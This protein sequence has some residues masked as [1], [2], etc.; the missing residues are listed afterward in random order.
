MYDFLLETLYA[1]YRNGLS[2]SALGAVVYVLL[3]QRKVR[4]ILKSYIPWLLEDDSE[5]KSY[6]ENQIVIMENQKRMMEGMG[7]E[8]HVPTSIKD[9]QD[10]VKKKEKLWP[11]HVTMLL[12]VRYVKKFMKFGGMKMRN[13]LKK[14]GSRKFQALLTSLIINGVS[15]YL[16]I[17]GTVDIDGA[18][19]NWIPVINMTA[20]TISTWVY[21]LVEGS[22]DKSQ[23][24]GK[25]NEL[26]YTQDTSA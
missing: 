6:I 16:F 20:G 18:L 9:L 8:W 10:S 11:W 1:I 13:Y 2:L 15:F 3:K 22:V 24:G 26:D 4:K 25:D 14:L 5:V 23:T 21:I 7:L 12:P 17:S 19:N